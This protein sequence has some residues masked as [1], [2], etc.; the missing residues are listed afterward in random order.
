MS[1]HMKISILLFQSISAFLCSIVNCGS[2]SDLPTSSMNE[3]QNPNVWIT[4]FFH[5]LYRRGWRTVFFISLLN[6]YILVM[7]FTL[8]FVIW[9]TYV[10]ADC[11][12]VGGLTIGTLP[13]RSV[14]LQHIE[15][16]FHSFIGELICLCIIYV[17]RF[18]WMHSL[19]RGIQSQQ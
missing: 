16:N 8:L 17:Y 4:T 19:C 3:G 13:K 9:T 7:L 12:M 10:D 11:V 2:V 18:G 1:E 5:W 14:S 15:T 6:F